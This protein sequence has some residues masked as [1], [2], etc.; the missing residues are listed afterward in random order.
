MCGIIGFVGKK[1]IELEKSANLIFHRG[2]DKTSIEYN[3]NFSVAF[4][5]LSI[6]DTSDNAMQPFKSQGVTI[7]FNGEIYN[8]I[9]LKQQYA[10]EFISKTRSDGEILTFLYKKYGI[11]FL[12]KINGMFSIVIFDE[13]KKRAFFIRDRFAEKPLYYK[14][15]NNVFY[16]TSEIK[17][18]TPLIS[19]NEDLTNLNVNINCLF[20]PQGL[21]LFKDIYSVNP[22]SYIELNFSKKLYFK[23][24]K[25]YQ[26]SIKLEKMNEA[27][28]FEKMDHLLK[29]SLKIRTRSDVPVGMFLSGGLDSSC[30]AYYAKKNYDKQL[31]S[32]TAI[33]EEKFDVEQNLTDTDI[34]KKYS[35]SLNISHHQVQFNFKFF[36]ENFIDVIFNCEE[37]F[38]DSGNLMYY[39]LAKKAKDLGIKVVLKGNGGDEIFGGYPWQRQV[40]LFPNSILNFSFKNLNRNFENIFSSQIFLKQRKLQKFLQILLTPK[41]WHAETLADGIFFNF[42]DT[43]FKKEYLKKN[44]KYISKN[45]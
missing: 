26:P 41:I 5:R 34:P 45:L 22:G 39:G 6:I 16:F 23:E 3:E 24:I 28:I 25:W 42:F 10:K 37:L 33:I 44:L 9:E 31:T 17:A 19:L 43:D 30:V 7:Y 40:N 11:Q 32:L 38:L 36:N 29:D 21:S 15:E 27:F 35:S 4:N 2:P 14:L 18:L 8:Y 1:K 13:N 20:L 12:H